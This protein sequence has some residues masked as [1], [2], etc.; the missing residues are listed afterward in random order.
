MQ[1]TKPNE[2]DAVKRLRRMFG[3]FAGKRRR[4]RRGAGS[5]DPDGHRRVYVDGKQV[6]EH[7]YVWEQANGPIPKGHFIHHRDGH[8]ANNALANLECIT[9]AEHMRMHER[10]RDYRNRFCT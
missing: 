7:R 3:N 9:R 6:M 8:K 2:R 4:A 10:R 1:R 5:I